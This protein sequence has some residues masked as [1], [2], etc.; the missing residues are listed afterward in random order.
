MVA[1][2]VFVERMENSWLHH[3][4][5]NNAGMHRATPEFVCEK[6]RFPSASVTRQ[7]SLHHGLILSDLRDSLAGDHADAQPALILKAL[8]PR[9]RTSRL[10]W[11]RASN[12]L[13]STGSAAPPSPAHQ[14]RCRRTNCAAHPP[15]SDAVVSTSVVERLFNQHPLARQHPTE[16]PTAEAARP[17][18]IERELRRPRAAVLNQLLSNAALVRPNVDNAPVSVPPSSKTSRLAFRCHSAC[19]HLRLENGAAAERLGRVGDLSVPSAIPGEQLK[20]LRAC[21]SGSPRRASQGVTF[22]ANSI[23]FVCTRASSAWRR[24]CGRTASA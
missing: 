16:M 5:L 1:T 18:R 14:D 11:C 20:D 19:G 3:N 17:Q 13:S 21:G 22:L 24:R 7:R 4:T 12:A 23:G 2:L 10:A 8:P 6:R 15:L 9:T